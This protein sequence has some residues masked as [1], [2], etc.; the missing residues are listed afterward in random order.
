MR[1]AGR[2]KVYI[3]HSRDNEPALTVSS[4]ETFAVCKMPKRYLS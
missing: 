2:E 4:G 1:T 3:T